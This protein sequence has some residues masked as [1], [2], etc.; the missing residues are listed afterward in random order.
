MKKTL[1]LFLVAGTL[2]GANCGGPAPM[3][4]TRVVTPTISGQVHESVDWGDPPLAAAV[5]EVTGGDGVKKTGMSDDSGFYR[6]AAG[7]GSVTVTASK[8]GFATKTTEFLL[9]TD[10][11]LNFSL[12]PE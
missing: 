10:M 1:A 8:P 7:P 3:A 6:I 9:M 12:A 5:V 2:A 4:P 11:V